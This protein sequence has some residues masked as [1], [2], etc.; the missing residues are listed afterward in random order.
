MSYLGKDSEDIAQLE[1]K[2]IQDINQCK[3]DNAQRL[4]NKT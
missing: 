3:I 1:V 2:F 4:K